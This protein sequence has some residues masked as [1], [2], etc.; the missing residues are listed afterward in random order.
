MWRWVGTGDLKI[1]M[2][3]CRPGVANASLLSPNSFI[4]GERGRRN[5]VSITW[6]S[7]RTRAARSGIGCC[8]LRGRVGDRFRVLPT[9]SVSSPGMTT[10][11]WGWVRLAMWPQS[12]PAWQVPLMLS[13]RTRAVRS[14]IGCSMLRARVGN[15]FWV[16][17][18][19]TRKR[20]RND[21]SLLHFAGW[22]LDTRFRAD[23]PRSS[24]RR[25]RK[26]RPKG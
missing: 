4:V 11:V 12:A 19:L 18:P 24:P 21:W 6:L 10:L 25:A 7:F 23:L 14:G 2:T 17:L 15:R 5:P 16:P 9:R 26:R 13:F 1:S 20:P 8:V 22:P 3:H